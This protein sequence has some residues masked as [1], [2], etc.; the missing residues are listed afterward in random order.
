MKEAY[1]AAKERWARK[2]AGTEKPSVRS[3]DRLPPGQRQVSNFPV[4]DLGVKPEL[5][6]ERWELKIGGHV[7]NPVVLKWAEF[8]ALPQFKDV[9]D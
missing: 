1:I 5:P 2:M 6:P 7:E 3:E 8:L 4:L 9:S